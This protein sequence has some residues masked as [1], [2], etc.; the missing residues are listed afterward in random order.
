MRSILD[1]MIMR[2][3]THIDWLKNDLSRANPN[4]NL[5]EAILSL[6]IDSPVLYSNSNPG[7]TDYLISICRWL[8]ESELIEYWKRISGNNNP[9][10]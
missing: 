2:K 4:P 6:P 10:Q 5:T 3:Y 7:L 9:R 1:V 8:K